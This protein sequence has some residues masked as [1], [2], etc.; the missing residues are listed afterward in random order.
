MTAGDLLADLLREG[1]TLSA[2]GGRLHVEAP[3]GVLTPGFRAALAGHKAELL[4]IL[5][6]TPATPVPALRRVLRAWYAIS[7]RDG[8]LATI[9]KALL[10]PRGPRYT[11]ALLS[12]IRRLWDDTG[13]AFAEA[14][15]CQEARAYHQ[16]T[17][18]CPH[19][20]EIAGKEPDGGLR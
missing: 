18:R 10:V 17:G 11:R 12:E 13:P 16:E 8:D 15:E 5:A 4:R 6:T 9:E 1:V 14:V 2:V 7:A 3:R 19:C 20:G